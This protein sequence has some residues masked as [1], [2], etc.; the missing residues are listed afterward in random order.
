MGDIF[1]LSLRF[2]CGHAVENCFAR[3]GAPAVGRTDVGTSSNPS[4]P[5]PPFRGQPQ[6]RLQMAC[7]FSPPRLG[8]PA[9]PLAPSSPLAPT[10]RRALGQSHPGLASSS[11]ALGG[12]EN[13]AAA[14]PDFSAPPG[15]VCAL[16]SSVLAAGGAGTSA[17]SAGPQGAVPART[18]IDTTEAPQPGVDR[19]FQGLVLHRRRPAAGAVDRARSVQPLRAV[20]AVAAQSGRHGRTPGFSAFVSSAGVARHHPGGQWFAPRA[21]GR[22]DCRGCRSGGCGWASAASSPTGHAR[23]TTRA[24]N[25]FTVVTSGRWWPRAGRNDDACNGVRI[26]G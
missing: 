17:P 7:A 22:W 10:T 21:Q 19:G 25:S 20:F 1:Q 18:R 23:A 5:L 4:N 11:S 2:I 8:W 6:N 13:L 3:P 14:P 15:A 26:A 16:Y 9:R 12:Q 24:T